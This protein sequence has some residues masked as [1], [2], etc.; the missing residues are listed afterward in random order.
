MTNLELEYNRLTTLP[1]ELEYLKRLTKLNASFNQLS[2][3]PPGL[4]SLPKLSTLILSN[5][6]F[7]TLPKEL[8][9]MRLYRLSLDGNPFN[10]D[11]RAEIERIG[12]LTFVRQGT[13]LLLLLTHSQPTL[14]L[15]RTAP[16]QS[17]LDGTDR[18]TAWQKAAT[19]Q[20]RVSFDVLLVRGD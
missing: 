11:I 8:L 18:S 14:T 2:Q 5:N 4:A 9:C 6:E 12:G 17:L 13:S 19:P 10:D 1:V 15:T 7:E 20:F 16:V 3:L